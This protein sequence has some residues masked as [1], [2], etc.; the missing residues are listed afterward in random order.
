M[1][2][3]SYLLI[4]LLVVGIVFIFAETDFPSHVSIQSLQILYTSFNG[5]TTNFYSYNETQL[6]NLS[7]V[8]LEKTAYG[9]VVFEAPLDIISMAG[10]DW[11]VN[12]DGDLNMSSNLIVVDNINLPGINKQAV[13]SIYGLGF[14]NPVIYNNGVVCSSCQL[15]SYSSGTIRF[16]VNSF[17]GVYYIREG[18]VPPVCG[19]GVCE[20]GETSTSCPSDCKEDEPSTPGGGGD[21][22][23]TNE[24]KPPVYDGSYDFIISPTLME[25]KL[26]KGS[27]FQK[28][29]LVK[30][31]G[32]KAITLGVFVSGLQDFIFPEVNVFTLQP[33]ESKEI[34]LDIYVSDKRAA[35]VYLGKVRFVNVNRE[36][37]C[38]VVLQVKEREALFDIRTTV[39]KKYIN[40]GGRVRAN[41]SLINMG[42][43]RNFDVNLEYK[44]LDFDKNE[45][46]V[47]MEQFAINQSYT[48]VF[49]L[50]VP[51]DMKM[52]NYV[53]YAVVSY[54]DINATSYDTFTVEKVSY[55]AW[56]I[57]LILILIL[58]YLAYRWYEERKYKLYEELR[59]KGP[60]K[61]EGEVIS[62]FRVKKEEGEVVGK[63]VPELP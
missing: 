6:S 39:L 27:Y 14:T 60:L 52:G 61:K 3:K 62:K 12:F 49:F 8:V 11:V 26:S 50:D 23:P 32:T 5:T 30:N 59:K 35:D 16:R 47:K 1:R 28:K 53:F 55:L 58:M 10:I 37:D 36:H 56:I 4:F 7:N 18:A 42:D 45:Y 13:L 15:I 2:W 57:L 54:K 19:N 25:V 17:N 9:K 48:N 43:L 44:I 46:T 21:D 40:P 33:E 41:I 38:D 51:E 63:E 31:N 24:T 22:T 34:R 20:S 29:I